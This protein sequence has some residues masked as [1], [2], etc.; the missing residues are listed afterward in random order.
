MLDPAATILA[1][2]TAELDAE[3]AKAQ[4]ERDTAFMAAS[5]AAK[6]LVE[7]IALRI[8]DVIAERVK[9][10][11]TQRQHAVTTGRSTAQLSGIKAELTAL[12]AEVP[13]RVNTWLAPTELW[14]HHQR[15][16]RLGSGW[17]RTSHQSSTGPSS[18]T[19]AIGPKL[20]AWIEGFM[21]RHNYALGVPSI[22]YF[23]WVGPVAEALKRYVAKIER[24]NDADRKLLTA[25]NA[26]SI[27]NANAMWD[28]A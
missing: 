7:Q 2:M 5:G 21:K 24:L 25:T 27:H 16:M 11:I 20:E 3:I 1:V 17:S 10:E 15:N 22:G 14:P 6:D 13:E 4:Q 28:E 12:L 26:K 9:V 23:D 8:N 18:L 19:D